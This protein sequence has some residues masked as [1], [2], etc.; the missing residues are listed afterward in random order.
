VKKNQKQVRQNRLSPSR[1]SA[2]KNRTILSM[3]TALVIEDK[4]EL[5]DLRAQSKYRWITQLATAFNV[6]AISVIE[7]LAIIKYRRRK[8]I[9]LVP[10]LPG[11]R[12]RDLMAIREEQRQERQRRRDTPITITGIAPFAI[13]A[14]V[15]VSAPAPVF[16]SKLDAE[17]FEIAIKKVDAAGRDAVD[18]L[19]GKQNQRDL[20]EARETLR[21]QRLH[22]AALRVEM[23]TQEVN[24]QAVYTAAGNARR[25]YDRA[26]ANL[27]TAES[28]FES[29]VANSS[30]PAPRFSGVHLATAYGE[31]VFSQPVYTANGV[32]IAVG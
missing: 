3:E 28:K 5:C 13:I 15:E 10:E 25:L 27:A 8:G 14:P 31:K 30:P 23:E 2:A 20:E 26:T 1:E 32:F 11:Y 12:H 6:S 9:E 4:L 21:M 18:L 29:L 22:H 7:L 24:L 17:K 16:A 19:N